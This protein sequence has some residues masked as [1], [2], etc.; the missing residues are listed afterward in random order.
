[1]RI[2]TIFKVLLFVSLD[3]CAA[4]VQ[5]HNTKVLLNRIRIATQ[6]YNLAIEA[7]C[8][9][10]T[11]SFE[12]L[13]N[14]K[15][16]K[17]DRAYFRNP[18][19]LLKSDILLNNVVFS[20]GKEIVLLVPI[21]EILQNKLVINKMTIN[22]N[23]EYELSVIK[24]QVNNALSYSDNKKIKSDSDLRNFISSS[25]AIYTKYIYTSLENYQK[26]APGSNRVEVAQQ[27]VF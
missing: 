27:Y 8:S 15:I 7:L 21:R 10:G 17:L 6:E 14:F 13:L 1:M 11:K 4:E 23:S 26:L 25:I 24:E 5:A 3:L 2:K 9:E 19:K 22:L 12:S 16:T 18:D 20:Y